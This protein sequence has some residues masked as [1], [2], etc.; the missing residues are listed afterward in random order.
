MAVEVVGFDV[1][2]SPQGNGTQD[3]STFLQNNE[4]ENF[5]NEVKENE[6]VKLGSQEDKPV[7]GEVDNALD[8]NVPKDVADEWPVPCQIYSFYFVKHRTYDDPVIKAKIEQVDKEIQKITQARI[9]IT[10]QLKHKKVSY[11]FP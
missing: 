8:A 2:H 1:A 6:L 3:D 11:M 9:R 7:K 4:N 10:D 5:D